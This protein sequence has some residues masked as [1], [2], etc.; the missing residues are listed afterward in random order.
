MLNLSQEIKS[1]NSAVFCSE[2][3]QDARPEGVLRACS[4]LGQA[5]DNLGLIVYF[6][7]RAYDKLKTNLRLS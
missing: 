5:Y 6:L 7:F 1:A 3:G 2:G 4:G